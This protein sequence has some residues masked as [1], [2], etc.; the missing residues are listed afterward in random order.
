MSL[1]A[2]G[3]LASAIAWFFA[4]FNAGIVLMSVL[5]LWL[6]RRPP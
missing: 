4:G 1:G 2:L 6:S 3:D 5:N